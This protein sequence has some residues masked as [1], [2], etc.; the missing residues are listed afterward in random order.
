MDLVNAAQVVMAVAAVVAVLIEIVRL[1]DDK[2]GILQRAGAK[3][4]S[5]LCN[6]LE[7][8]RRKFS[9]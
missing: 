6:I 4:Y 3:M 1:T 5:S 7:G 8:L 9:G 2:P